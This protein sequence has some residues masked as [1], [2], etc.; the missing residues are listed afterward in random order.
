MNNFITILE[1]FEL[2]EFLSIVVV[3]QMVAK[4]TICDCPV[5]YLVTLFAKLAKVG[6][7]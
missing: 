3:F 1:V 7:V 6:G 4:I 5:A 2:Q